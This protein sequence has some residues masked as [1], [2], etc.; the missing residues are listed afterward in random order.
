[1]KKSELRQIIREEINR[2][3]EESG[4]FSFKCIKTHEAKFQPF[5]GKPY[6]GSFSKGDKKKGRMDDKQLVIFV[7]DEFHADMVTYPINEVGKYWVKI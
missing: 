6:G 7:T 2:L 4:F 1:M 3:N 5:R